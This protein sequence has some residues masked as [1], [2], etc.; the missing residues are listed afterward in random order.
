MVG[1]P[2]SWSSRDQE[3]QECAAVS[4]NSHPLTVDGVEASGGSPM[5]SLAESGPPRWWVGVPLIGV[6]LGFIANRFAPE[7]VQSSAALIYR[8]S[9]NGQAA[10]TV[11]AET[12]RS[13]AP[14]VG[15]VFAVIVLTTFQFARRVRRARRRAK[16]EV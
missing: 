11:S 12:A 4:H 1:P 8:L 14:M 7:L 2:S 9:G 5:N 3:E 16:D 15:M 13:L 6:L 10:A